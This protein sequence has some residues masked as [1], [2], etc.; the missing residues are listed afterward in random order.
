ML[1]AVTFSMMAVSKYA[2][3]SGWVFFRVLMACVVASAWL[4]GRRT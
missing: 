2:N 4:F 1:L 3:R